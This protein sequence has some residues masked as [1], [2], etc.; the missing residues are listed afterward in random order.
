MVEAKY[1]LSLCDC[2]EAYLTPLCIKILRLRYNGK[3][4]M[5]PK[6]VGDILHILDE[7]VRQLEERALGDLAYCLEFEANGQMITPI[8]LAKAFRHPVARKIC[9]GEIKCARLRGYTAYR[10]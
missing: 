6:A 7:R 2:F 3:T 5:V 9:T 10:G 8:R 4:L 1:I